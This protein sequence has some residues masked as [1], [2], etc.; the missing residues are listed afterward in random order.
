MLPRISTAV[1]GPCTQVLRGISRVISVRRNG[2]GCCFCNSTGV[3]PWVST[4]TPTPGPYT[5]STVNSWGVTSL[6]PPPKYTAQPDPRPWHSDL[7]CRLEFL[8][9]ATHGDFSRQHSLHIRRVQRGEVLRLDRHVQPLEASPALVTQPSTCKAP[10]REPTWK[11]CISRRSP[12][13]S[14]AATYPCSVHPLPLTAGCH[15]AGSS[16]RARAVAAGYR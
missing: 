12:R 14:R 8:E 15:L 13:N 10:L 16:C 5:P 1:L 2:N 3:R 4:T 6:G 9:R 11:R 7:A